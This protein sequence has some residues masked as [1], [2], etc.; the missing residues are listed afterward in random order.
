MN[1]SLTFD[2]VLRNPWINVITRNDAAGFYEIKIGEID[3]VV[4]I[5]LFEGDGGRTN[6]ETS[7]YIQPPF[8]SQPYISP[9]PW[10][11][12][13]ELALDNA[14][15]NLCSWYKMALTSQHKPHKDWLVPRVPN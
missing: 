3:C 1:I 7:H 2:D 11:T 12:T 8:M 9:C 13:P 6:Y 5:Q 10:D 15:G 14:V 4:S